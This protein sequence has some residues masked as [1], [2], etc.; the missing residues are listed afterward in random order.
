MGA[1]RENFIRAS[2]ESGF[3]LRFLKHRD[4]ENT[5]FTMWCLSVISVTLCLLVPDLAK[6]PT[7]LVFEKRSGTMRVRDTVECRIQVGYHWGHAFRAFTPSHI[8]E[9]GHS[10]AAITYVAHAIHAALQP[11][12]VC[13]CASES[14]D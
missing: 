12:C 9:N 11:N 13:R 8:P 6:E 10:H 4:T 3:S 14:T 7:Q 1:L 2:C 5:E